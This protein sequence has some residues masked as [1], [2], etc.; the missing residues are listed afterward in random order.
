MS[1]E[2]AVYDLQSHDSTASTSD[3]FHTDFLAHRFQTVAL[4]LAHSRFAAIAGILLGAPTG[5][6]YAQSQIASYTSEPHS[7]TALL[8]SFTDAFTHL[9]YTQLPPVGLVYTTLS[10]ALACWFLLSLLTVAA[11]IWTHEYSLT[12]F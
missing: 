8:P 4:I 5:A 11:T 6:A 7:Q 10:C 1:A 12:E 9:L 3:H 2:L